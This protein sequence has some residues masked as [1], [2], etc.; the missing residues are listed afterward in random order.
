MRKNVV[1][2]CWSRYI[3]LGGGKS[4]DMI[5][6]ST[7]QTNGSWGNRHHGDCIPRWENN[8]GDLETK[9]QGDGLANPNEVERIGSYPVCLCA[10]V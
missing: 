1:H 5:P 2:K 7:M 9:A 8:S 4:S 6:P 3:N 10:T